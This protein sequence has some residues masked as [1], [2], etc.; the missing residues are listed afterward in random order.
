MIYFPIS[1]I[2]TNCFLT[3]QIVGA[4][5]VDKR[6]ASKLLKKHDRL[7]RVLITD[8]PK[9][10]AAANKDLGISLEYRQHKGFNN[11]AENSHQLTR[12][13]EKLTRRINSARQLKRFTSTHEQ[14]ANLFMHCQCNATGRPSER[15]ATR[16][17]RPGTE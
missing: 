17:S 6:A 2:D 3:Q 15:R 8:K 14:M 4:S 13:R 12:V 10:Y 11:R 7:P 5:P 16:P 1:A 9:N